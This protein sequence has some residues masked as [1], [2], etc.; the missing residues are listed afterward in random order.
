MHLSALLLILHCFL[1]LDAA[2]CEKCGAI[3]V[4]HAFYG[5]ERKFCSLSCARGPL[6]PPQPVSDVRQVEKVV[7]DG[8]HR[9][10]LPMPEVSPL[11]CSLMIGCITELILMPGD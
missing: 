9:P 5:K 7:N 1:F 10:I 11:S 6:P 3:G 4:K 8:T 2:V